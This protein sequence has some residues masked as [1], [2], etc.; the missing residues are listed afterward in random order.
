MLSRDIEDWIAQMDRPLTPKQ[1]AKAVLEIVQNLNRHP[2]QAARND[3]QQ[4]KSKDDP[5]S[6]DAKKIGKILDRATKSA[7]KKASLNIDNT[8][9]W[10]FLLSLLAWSIYGKDPGHPKRWNKRKLRRLKS[11]VAKLRL[12][13]PAPTEKSC[14]EQLTNDIHYVG[15]TAPTLRRRLQQAKKLDSKKYTSLK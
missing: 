11:K 12:R 9:D 2:R 7:F 5:P 6:E 4:E 10:A 1:R 15:L 14:C 8:E 3:Q 13:N